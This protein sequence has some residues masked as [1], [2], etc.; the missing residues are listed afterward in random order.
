MGCSFSQP[1]STLRGHPKNRHGLHLPRTARTVP[2]KQWSKEDL[3]LACKALGDGWTIRRAAEE[4]GVPKSTL[5]DRVSGRISFGARSGPP[6]YLTDQEEKELVSFLIGCAK[7]G[8]AKSRKEVLV[9]VQSFIAKKQ[10]KDTEDVSVT[11]GWWNSF[12]KRHPQLTV[13]TA[14]RLSYVRAIAHDPDVFKNYFDLLEDT[15]VMNKL[16]HEPARIF[17]CNESGFP[18]E[19]KP[20]KLIGMRG[21]KDLHTTTSGEKA[22]LTVLACVSASG[23]ALPP[24]IIFDRKRL[25]P[26]LTVGEIP[27]SIY[28]LS[29]N[30]WIDS[31]IF[32]EWFEKHFLT[33]VP[34]VR[35]LLLLLDGHSSH[36][37]PSLVKKA[38]ENDVLLFCLPPHTTHLAQ[39]LDRTCFSPL[40]KAWNE[41]CRLYMVMNPGK[42]I[43]RYNF[44]QIFAR[45]WG[46]A[47][48][49]SNIASGFRTTGVCPFNRKAIK[50]PGVDDV[51]EEPSAVLKTFLRP[52]SWP[53]SLSS[54]L[55]ILSSQRMRMLRNPSLKKRSGFSR[56]ALKMV[57]TLPVM[58]GT[59]G[60]Y[61]LTT[62]RNH[63][64]SRSAN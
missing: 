51:A 9:I 48:T 4:F 33:H 57:L 16:M 59:T 14:S 41:E 61:E 28:G 60:G 17:N 31:E 30:G 10:G 52:L 15:L 62:Q 54:A 11:T 26:E 64:T 20:G 46:K 42:K 47:M 50:I 27:G 25:K 45:A 3:K 36:Y 39:P 49:P 7:I 24:L 56:S 38:A 2:F 12:R 6:R 19:H 13:R 29:D 37:Q 32:E 58:T 40:K 53:T 18:L 44:T 43:N 55:H 34:P 1:I 21:Q 23:Y 63:M 35:P 5:Y 8:F 22:Q